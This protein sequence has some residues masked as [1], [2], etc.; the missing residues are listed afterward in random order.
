MFPYIRRSPSIPTVKQLSAAG[1]IGLKSPGSLAQHHR[2]QHPLRNI[3]APVYRRQPDSDTQSPRVD[4]LRKDK[5]APEP[6]NML[7]LRR[8]YSAVMPSP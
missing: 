1:D 3:P 7:G 8:L 5:R 2:P 4:S 6:G